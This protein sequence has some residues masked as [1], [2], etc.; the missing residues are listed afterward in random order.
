MEKIYVLFKAHS[1]MSYS[2]VGYQFNFI[3]YCIKYGIFEQK[4][5]RNEVICIGQLMKIIKACDQRPTET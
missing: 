4:H 5:T 3:E 1:G 2:E